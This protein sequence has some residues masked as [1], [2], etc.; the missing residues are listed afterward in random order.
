M[1]NLLPP[2]EKRILA[3]RQIQKVI[4][5]WGFLLF[6]FLVS[7]SLGLLAVKFSLAGQETFQKTLVEIEKKAFQSQKNQAAKKEALKL[8]QEVNFLLSFYEKKSEV[9]ELLKKIAFILPPGLSLESLSFQKEDS[10]VVLRGFAQ[11]R[12]DL[13]LFK[14]NLEREPAFKDVTFPPQ[15]WVKAKDIN[16]LVN[17]KTD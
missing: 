3:E 16:F 17:F 11:T 8:N 7:L 2:K 9:S 1:I 10:L 13:I 15:N 12:E 5:I 14:D 6:L 4:N